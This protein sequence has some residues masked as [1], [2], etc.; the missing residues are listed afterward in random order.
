MAPSP[1]HAPGPR[2]MELLTWS[3]VWLHTQW[4]VLMAREGVRRRRLRLS[5]LQGMGMVTDP[6]ISRVARAREGTA[7]SQLLTPMN[8]K[9]SSDGQTSYDSHGDRRRRARLP[10][11]DA[12]AARGGPRDRD[13]GRVRERAGGCGGDS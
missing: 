5:G 1:D 12:A 4:Y 10:G 6:L 13:R 7:T 3:E 2:S 8:G 9:D 11:G